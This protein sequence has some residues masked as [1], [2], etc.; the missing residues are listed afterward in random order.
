MCRLFAWHSQTPITLSQALGPD[1][2]TLA[3][4]SRIHNDGWGMAYGMGEE[5]VRIREVTPAFESELF[6]ESSRTIA[7]TAAIV[8]LRWATENLSVCEPNTHPFTKQGPSG[9]I[10]FIHNGGIARG[11]ELNALVDEDLLGA[12]EGDTDSELYFAALLTCLRRADGDVAAAFR[13]L[14]PG[15]E[16]IRHSSLNAML[17]TDTDLYVLC[18]HN[19]G[20]RPE[21][22]DED[23]YD[24]RW[25]LDDGVFTAWSSQVKPP[26]GTPMSQGDLVQVQ[27]ATG[28][29]TV[30][31]V[32]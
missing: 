16:A 24:L 15:L 13:L 27:R 31:R 22:T 12:L 19:A 18:R 29:V 23:Y 26:V 32:I 11:T 25:S 7:T 28:V 3:D 20:N 5:T 14:L 2:H 6:E 10:A 8:H 21:G 9:Q 17:L 1:A 4:L 30:H